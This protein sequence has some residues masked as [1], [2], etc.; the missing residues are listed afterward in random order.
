MKNNTNFPYDVRVQ[1]GRLVHVKNQE[2]YS[3]YITYRF[4]SPSFISFD[5]KYQRIHHQIQLVAEVN[6]VSTIY[7]EVFKSDDLSEI[8]FNIP[9][10][11]VNNQLIID[12]IVVFKEKTEWDDQEVMPGMPVAHLGTFEIELIEKRSRGL[13]VFVSD[14]KIKEVK[15]DFRNEKIEVRIPKH[16]YEWLLRN[17]ADPVVSAILSSQFGQIALIEACMKMQ[18]NQSL[19]H[20]PWFI[21]LSRLWKQYNKSG[22]D[23]PDNEEITGFVSHIL[24]KP[25]S[26]LLERLEES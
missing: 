4:E 3:N 14:D 2:T 26:Y 21:E 23:F 25:T 16:Q 12:C 11:D 9:K 18:V 1:S 17:Q 24:K 8:V 6:C 5:E 20:L 7:R 10:K 19:D 13:L 22:N 15:N